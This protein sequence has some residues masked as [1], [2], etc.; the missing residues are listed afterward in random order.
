MTRRR[1]LL[2]VAVAAIV[3]AAAV[4]AA[5]AL[6]GGNTQPTVSPA[7]TTTSSTSTTAAE[8]DEYTVATAI[9]DEVQVLSS[10]PDN[11]TPTPGFTP[12]LSSTNPIPRSSLDSVGVRVTDDGFAY[13]NPTYF[14]N[15]LLFLVVSEHDDWV[16]VLIQ[17]RPNGQTGW[18]STSEVELA[19]YDAVMELDLTTRVL[20]ATV[21]GEVIVE[22]VTTIGLPGNPTPTGLY[23]ITEVIPQS[24]TEG[25]F[26][27][28]ILATS[29]YSEELELFDNGL[30]IVAVHGTNRPD[31][32]GEMATNGCVR[33]TNDLITLLAEKLPP[34]VP[35]VVVESPATDTDDEAGDDT[36]GTTA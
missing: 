30:P 26:G 6:T 29:A 24:F 14:D 5:L 34:G 21:D 12:R 27:P 35:L 22:A 33:L 28:F 4:V 7:P 11:L 8:N 32:M 17:A 31:L 36:E 1:T 23:F 18:V 10:P 9:V 3:A 25:D 15:P 19:T 13:D 16:E 20:K 2:S